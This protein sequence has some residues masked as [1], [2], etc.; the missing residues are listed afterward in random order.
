MN[1]E[2]VIEELKKENADLKDR[3]FDAK[4]CIAIQEKELEKAKKCSAALKTI[5][6]IAEA[7][8]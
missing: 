7:N 5:Q 2:Y 1:D 8:L 6:G 4:N 3:L